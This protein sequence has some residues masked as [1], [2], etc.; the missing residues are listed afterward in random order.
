MATGVGTYYFVGAGTGGGTFVNPFLGGNGSATAPTYSFSA[1]SSTGWYYDS[2][3]SSL[4]AS[5]SGQV[6]AYIK[7]D[8]GAFP[9]MGLGVTP[10]ATQTLTVQGQ[11][12]NNSAF[13]ADFR[14]LAGSSVLRLRNDGQILSNVGIGF[15]SGYNGSAATPPFSVN[16][17]GGMYVPGSGRI[18]LTCGGAAALTFDAS[19]NATVTGTVT[20]AGAGTIRSGTNTPEGAVVG[21]VGDIFLRTN[22]GA[23]T[24]LY[25]KESG[26]ATNT[27]WVAK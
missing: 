1:A 5:A 12:S 23:A 14:N 8:T 11:T 15:V 16:G 19:R 18:G 9:I 2:V 13:V 27:G 24:C 10:V 25:V 4:A 7:K 6:A 22:G 26:A 17:E 20:V 3:T 21:S